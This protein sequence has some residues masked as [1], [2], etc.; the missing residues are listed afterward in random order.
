VGDFHGV[1]GAEG[2]VSFRKAA[3]ASATLSALF[4]IVYG[5]INWLT[6]QRAD[7]GVLF[8]GWERLIPFVPL[9]IV[10][11]MSIDLLFAVAP[12][13][14]KSEEELDTF[15]WRVVFV[16]LIAGAC[17]LLFPLKYTFVRPAVS[18]WQGTLFGMLGKMD[19]PYNLLPS[20]HI[21]LRTILAATYARH[22]KGKWKT[23]SHLWF[24][25]IGAST[26]LVYQHHV[27]DVVFGFLVAWYAFYLFPSARTEKRFV[28]NYGIGMLYLAGFGVMAAIIL[29]SGP[30]G[31]LLLWP[32]SSLLIVAAG[33]FKFGPQIYR[34]HGGR[35]PWRA[36]MALGPVLIGHYVSHWFYKRQCAA[37]DEVAPNVWIGRRL[38]EREAE[39][40]VRAGVTAVL[41]VTAEFTE[42]KAFRNVSYL[43]V[44]VLDLSAPTAGQLREM[45]AFVEEE[46]KRGIVYVH[47]K[48]GYSRSAAAVAAYLLE[49][50]ICENAEDAF[51]QLRE[52]RPAI[53]V[54]PEIVSAVMQYTRF[55]PA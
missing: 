37:Y 24:S 52:V 16:V 39:A 41:D 51:G 2:F 23:A 55:A 5:T 15:A 10:P 42:A 20:Q 9:M 30:W 17:F 53:V 27:M 31:A 1:A 26:L 14:C 47:C 32:A 11:Y 21:T 34:K 46:S 28:P 25:L 12:F 4:M 8:F 36:R 3:V 18:G 35:V 40:A 6:A 13:L 44:P 7:V 43:S 49:S 29:M 22:L 19:Q 38:N 45:A 48:A 54:R 33:Y 50:G